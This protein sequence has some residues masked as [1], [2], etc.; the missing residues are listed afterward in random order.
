MTNKSE[1]SRL[2]LVKAGKIEDRRSTRRPHILEDEQPIV[3]DIKEPFK[4]RP[5]MLAIVVMLLLM[6]LLAIAGM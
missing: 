1:P 6:L 4:L 5:E 3:P 2:D